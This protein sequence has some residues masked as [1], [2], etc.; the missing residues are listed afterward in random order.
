MNYIKLFE[1][2]N[3]LFDDIKDILSE[4]S[5]KESAEVKVRQIKRGPN[6]IIV[7]IL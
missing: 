6:K 1:I 7:T 3:S 5:D 4:I 2:F